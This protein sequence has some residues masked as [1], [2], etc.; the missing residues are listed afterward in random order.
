MS[1]FV[2]LH[3]DITEWGW[4][5]KPKTFQLFVYCILRANYKD[6]MY[7][8]T[9]IKRGEFVTSYPILAKALGVTV[10]SIRTSLE[11]LKSTHELTVKTS[12]QGTR[13]IVNNYHQYQQ[14]DTHTDNPTDR[15]PTTNK[16]IKNIKNNIYPEKSDQTKPKSPLKPDQDMCPVTQLVELYTKY[17]KENNW[18][19]V[20]TI[21]DNR[22]KK[23]SK[24]IKVFPDMKTWETIF[25]YI[26]QDSFWNKVM[27]VDKIYR[28]DNY[29]AF[30]EKSQ[31]ASPKQLIAELKQS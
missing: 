18:A 12:N 16:N 4:M 14:R 19:K 15:R 8:G 13:I 26:K 27:D 30:Y 10:R 2:K 9:M 25:T 6:K 23:L 5:S 24:A 17:A 29:L 3:R 7:Q 31:V 28:N 20:I 11:H 22:H 1:G 21:N